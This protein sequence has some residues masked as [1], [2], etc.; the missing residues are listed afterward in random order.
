VDGDGILD[1]AGALG[2]TV[3]L[4]NGDGTFGGASSYATGG[5]TQAPGDFDLDGRIDMVGDADN[6][7]RIALNQTG[8]KALG[9]LAD[10]TTLVWPSVLGAQHYD[11]YRGDLSA[12]VDSDDDGLPDDGYG[13]CISGLDDDTRDTFFVDAQ[14]PTPAGAGFFY[15]RSSIDAQGDSGLGANSAGELRPNANPCP[16]PLW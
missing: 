8:P 5:R 10:G 15:L 1:L 6:E 12:L 11:V 3:L 7:V 4:G 16:P 13:V 9:F 14:V 2:L